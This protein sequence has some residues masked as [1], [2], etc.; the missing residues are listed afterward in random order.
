MRYALVVYSK[1]RLK[2]STYQPDTAANPAHGQL[3]RENI[4]FPYPIHSRLRTWFRE[5]V[6]AVSTRIS[7]L[8]LQTWAIF[9]GLRSERLQGNIHF[10]CSAT[11]SRIDNY[12]R[13]MPSLLDTM[14]RHTCS[15]LPTYFEH[16]SVICWMGCRVSGRTLLCSHA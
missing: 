6:S 12:T 10:P 11:M 8:I 1:T 13:L 9:S 14:T 5:T 15:A 2:Q 3:N 7:P 4:I 16:K